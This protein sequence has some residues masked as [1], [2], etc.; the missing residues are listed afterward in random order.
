QERNKRGLRPHI[1]SCHTGIHIGGDCLSF[2]DEALSWEG[3]AAACASRGGALASLADPRAVL[4]YS[5][6]YYDGTNFWIGGSDAVME[7]HWVWHTGVPFAA[8][9]PWGRGE[10][11]SRAGDHEDCLELRGKWYN[12]QECNRTNRYICEDLEPRL[13]VPL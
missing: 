4:E 11:D 2:S 3:A 8:N 10:P 5:Q 6:E 13:L 9:F 7:G 1:G 12:D